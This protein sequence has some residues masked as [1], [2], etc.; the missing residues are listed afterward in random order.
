MQKDDAEVRLAD[1]V[2]NDRIDYLVS[3]LKGAVGLLPLGGL[4]AEAVG[5]TIP[6]QRIDR[7]AD[8]IVKVANRLDEVGLQ[9]DEMANRFRSPEFTDIFEEAMLQAGKALSEERRQYI[10]N[11]LFNGLAMTDFDHARSK[12]LLFLLSDLSDPELV[13]LTFSGLT[14]QEF[15]NEFYDLHELILDDSVGTVIGSSAAERELAALRESYWQNLNALGLTRGR[16]G[17]GLGEITDLGRL[18]LR[19]I[20]AP[21]DSVEEQ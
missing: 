16:R 13:W 1:A 2:S 15:Q 20:D 5:A 9:I 6:R 4:V 14:T 17:P 19:Y 8:V 18:L 7:M 3:A 12:K 11:L 10:A 21:T